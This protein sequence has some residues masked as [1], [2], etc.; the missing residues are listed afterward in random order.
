MTTPRWHFDMDTIRRIAS[1]ALQG[2]KDQAGNPVQWHAVDI[3]NEL[4]RAGNGPT[5]VAAATLH[6]VLE[7]SD[8]SARRLF[9]EL[10][11]R[12][13]LLDID[14]IL[15][16]VI[17]LTREQGEVYMDYIHRIKESSDIAVKVKVED[18]RHHLE[19]R[20]DIAGS[21]VAR[22]EKALTVLTS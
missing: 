4:E 7:D 11:T 20:K 5:A 21:L 14:S 8:W 19:N 15:K 13:A 2:R 9:H 6:D 17:A 3:A 22:Y 18:L 16:A 10:A 1:E 12:A